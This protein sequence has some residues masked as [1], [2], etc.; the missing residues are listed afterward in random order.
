MGHKAPDC[1]SKNKAA[2][3]NVLV[4]A[5]NVPLNAKYFMTVY[6]NKVELDAFIDLG[7]SV[8][9]LN[10]TAIKKLRM[11]Y[12]PS[13]EVVRGYG[14]AVVRPLGKTDL[15]EIRLGNCTER[16]TFLVVSDDVQS[17]PVIVGQPFTEARA[18]SL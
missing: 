5:N 3:K 16:L 2:E 6:V 1:P 4:A 10:E 7:S 13:A 18:F 8:M 9:L 11:R 17:I 14:G 12:K 15:L